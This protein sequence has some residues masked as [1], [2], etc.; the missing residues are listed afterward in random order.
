MGCISVSLNK[1][2]LQLSTF[3]QFNY[4][5]PFTNQTLSFLSLRC[6]PVHPRPI[7]FT[8]PNILTETA[9]K[10]YTILKQQI[11]KTVIKLC[12]A[13]ANV[14]QTYVFSLSWAKEK[15]KNEIIC[16]K[17]V[18]SVKRSKNETLICTLY[19]V[20][21]GSNSCMAGGLPSPAIYDTMLL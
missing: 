2:V 18:R 8:L 16:H 9:I 21:K 6:N 3:E 7:P 14:V 11:W 4:N 19:S 17:D 20:H 1:T 10:N 12:L 13:I 5:V 15:E